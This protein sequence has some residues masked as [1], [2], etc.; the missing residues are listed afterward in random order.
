MAYKKYIKRNGKLYGP[1]VYHSKRVDGKVVSEYH[2]TNKGGL[3]KRI[4]PKK[5][6]LISIGFFLAAIVL[7]WVVFFSANLT[8]RATSDFSG[9]VVNGEL[10]GKL[11][12]NLKSGE[13]LPKDSV[14]VVNN[15]GNITEYF[16]SDLVKQESI[17][18]TFFVDGSQLSG[19]GE[20]YGFIGKK[21]EI[22]PVF[23]KLDIIPENLSS[24]GGS[25][26]SD[27]VAPVD[28]ATEP[29]VETPV[30]ETP[31]V[32]TLVNETP[33]VETPVN[34]TPVTETPVVETP[35]TE[36]PVT[37][38]SVT[39]TPVVE[40]PVAEAAPEVT[41]EEPV[42]EPT[43]SPITGN[44]ISN[45]FR[46]VGTFFVGITGN[47]VGESQIVQGDVEKG[48]EFVYNVPENSQVNFVAN[49]IMTEEGELDESV[50]LLNREGNKVIVTTTYSIVQEGYGQEFLVNEDKFLVLDFG[51]VGVA[52]E[53]GDI[54]VN[55]EFNGTSVIEFSGKVSGV[56]PINDSQPVEPVNK[57]INQTVEEVAQ[58]VFN[59]TNVTAR[60]FENL[61][62]SEAEKAILRT[63]FK[64]T[65]VNTTAEDYKDKTI[66]T[67]S[68]GGYEMSN[69]YE[70]DLDN[71]TLTKLIENDR[72][73]WLKD[74]ARGLSGKR[75]ISDSR[76]ELA[77]LYPIM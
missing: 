75:T 45:L 46:G 26:G 1:Y 32:E 53:E 34:E 67:F 12:L 8:G 22:V 9:Y 18:S 73:L 59:T 24:G 66:V 10:S 36:T 62:L 72:I 21:E 38:T 54:N 29:V 17:L 15:N 51:L 37:E 74:L 44:I 40:A 4:L 20:G 77:S 60:E 55:V 7:L 27:I 19:T 6:T 50:L 48:K 13:L 11:N 16:L 39:E 64:M 70:K 25:S 49:S 3:E 31:A 52:F 35:V 41:V 76:E 23:F 61:T 30:N 33:A 63:E 56:A 2:G 65:V 58:E 28:N 57:T 5:M 42:A 68:L 43:P 69:S 71:E 14:V 47:V